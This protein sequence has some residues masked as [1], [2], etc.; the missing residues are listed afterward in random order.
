V[1]PSRLVAV[2]SVALVCYLALVADRGVLLLR[3]PHLVAKGLGAGVAL[4]P[5]IGAWILW[6]ELRFGRAA[7]AL[8]ERAGPDPDDGTLERRPSGRL[9]R[10]SAD[11]MFERRRAEVEAHPDDWRR[12]YHLA[13]AYRAAGDPGRGRRA[14]RHAIRLAAAAADPVA[15]G[16][17]PAP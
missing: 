9:D 3:D 14:M 10:A 2:L 11:A 8:A 12:W 6:N 17:Q 4:L 1:R 15:D 13:I 16:K 5:L 7:A